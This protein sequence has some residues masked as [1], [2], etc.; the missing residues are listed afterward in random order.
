MFFRPISPRS[1]ST[2][3]VSQAALAIFMEVERLE[4]MPRQ[5]L[6]A[7]YQCLGLWAL[8]LGGLGFIG[9]VLFFVSMVFLL[10]DFWY[11]LIVF[12][13]GRGGCCLSNIQ[14]CWE[15][16]MSQSDLERSR[17]VVPSSLVVVLMIGFAGGIYHCCTAGVADAL[18]IL[19]WICSW[20]TWVVLSFLF[21]PPFGK[22]NVPVD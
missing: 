8:G 16:L 11:M 15:C 18:L 22:G 10:K 7:E 21:Q 14:G 4:S 12:L 1:S 17:S 2:S 3:S 5:L 20:L 6:E 13:G 19:L 9:D